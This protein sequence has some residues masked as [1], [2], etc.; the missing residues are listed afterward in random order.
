MAES[1]TRIFLSRHKH[2]ESEPLRLTSL[3]DPN[4]CTSLTVTSLHAFKPVG[5]WKARMREVQLQVQPLPRPVTKP[6]LRAS[7]VSSVRIPSVSPLL[8]QRGLKSAQGRFLSSKLK[9]LG[10]SWENWKSTRG[11]GFAYKLP[12][13]RLL[14]RSSLELKDTF[15]GEV[16]GKRCMTSIHRVKSVLIASHASTFN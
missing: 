10:E 12:S 7:I 16:T 3:P 14:K 1:L 2:T 4:L 5:M 6:K 8:F 15:R 13:E 11:G 9:G